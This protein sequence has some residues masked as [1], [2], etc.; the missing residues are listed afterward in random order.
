MILS[1]EGTF[2]CYAID[3]SVSVLL[4]YSFEPTVRRSRLYRS[5]IFSVECWH[6]ARPIEK[7]G[8][9]QSDSLQWV[10]DTRF[11]SAICVCDKE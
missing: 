7:K 9:K 11:S 8:K 6:N 5:F 10:A 3:K 1:T 2:T 4:S